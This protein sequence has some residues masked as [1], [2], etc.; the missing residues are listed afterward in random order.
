MDGGEERA[1]RSSVQCLDSFEGDSVPD[2]S[3]LW[4]GKD[5]L[6][7]RRSCQ[8]STRLVLLVISRKQASCAVYRGMGADR[9]ANAV[10]FLDRNDCGVCGVTLAD[11][12][13]D[14]QW[15]GMARPATRVADRWRRRCVN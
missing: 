7:N 14:A 10:C 13:A 6:S 3:T 15:R 1:P 2:A 4:P 11:V 8:R 5:E 9:E 12:V